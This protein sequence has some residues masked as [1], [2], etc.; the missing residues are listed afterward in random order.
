MLNEEQIAEYHNQGYLK[1]EQLFTPEEAGQLAAAMVRV[2]EQW[3]Q[4]TI[5]W[6]GP[7]RD[8]P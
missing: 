6:V 5:G 4:E 7:W 3:G 2:I 8:S 1:V